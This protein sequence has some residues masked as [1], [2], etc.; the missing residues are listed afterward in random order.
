MTDDYREE[1]IAWEVVVDKR[2]NPKLNHR[3][4]KIYQSV[5]VPKKGSNIIFCPYCDKYRELDRFNVGYGLIEKG[6]SDCGMTLHDF[7]MKRVNQLRWK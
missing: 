6:C 5:P 4:D 2:G 1:S 7:H 3:G